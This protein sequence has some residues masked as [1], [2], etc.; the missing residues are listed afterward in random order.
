M[1]AHVVALNKQALGHR[2]ANYCLLLLP[3]DLTSLMS[4][5][6]FKSIQ[7]K[8]LNSNMFLVVC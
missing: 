5:K 3:I 2:S 4:A 7:Q 1:A 6:Y 8:V